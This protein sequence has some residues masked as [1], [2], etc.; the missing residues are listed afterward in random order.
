MITM[1]WLFTAIVEVWV[2]GNK[3]IVENANAIYLCLYRGFFCLSWPSFASLPQI[4]SLIQVC[5]DLTL[6]KRG[7]LH[8]AVFVIQRSQN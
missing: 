4:N 2:A 5:I 1:L 7:C 3:V 6:H 8:F